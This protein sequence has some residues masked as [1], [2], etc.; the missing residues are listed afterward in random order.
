MSKHTTIPRIKAY[1]TLTPQTIGADQT[2]D[3]A[4]AIMHEYRLR[5]LPVLAAGRLVGIVSDRDLH[6]VETFHVIRVNFMK[7]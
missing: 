2:M 6:M 3:R 5:H 1:M 4:H 7:L